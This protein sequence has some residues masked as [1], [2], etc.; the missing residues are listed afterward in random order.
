M[1]ARA[2]T[3]TEE[4]FGE[5]GGGYETRLTSC[6]NLEVTAGRQI[7]ETSLELAKKMTPGEVPMPPPAPPFRGPRPPVPPELE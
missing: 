5:H 7:V 3:A 1:H 6:S 2:K 4:A